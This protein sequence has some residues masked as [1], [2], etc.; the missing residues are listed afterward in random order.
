[1]PRRLTPWA[2]SFAVFLTLLLG[3]VAIILITR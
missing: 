1:M 3:L 2:V